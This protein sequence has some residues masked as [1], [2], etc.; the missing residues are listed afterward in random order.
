M[1]HHKHS[2]VTV[3][4]EESTK[5]RLNRLGKI[6]Q[7]S[8]HWLMKQAIERYLEH[9]E[10]EELEKRETLKRWQEVK[11][12]LVIEHDKIDAWLNTWGTGSE[13]E[14]PK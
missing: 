5:T 2:A 1:K 6:R 3:K 4:L 12:G 14:H 7:R 8:S 10:H 13:K 11:S 9:E